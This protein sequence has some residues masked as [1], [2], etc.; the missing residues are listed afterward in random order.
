MFDALYI[1]ATG[2]QAQQ[3]N[4]DTIANNLANVN[5]DGFKKG[6]AAFSDLMVREASRLLPGSE[7]AE[8]LGMDRTLGAG[9][10]IANVSKLFDQ[11]GLKK[12]E[13]AYD[14][15][16][17]GEG[18]LEVTLPD[19]SSAYMRGGTFKVNRDGLL[20]T[21]GGFPL[22]PNLAIPDNAQSLIIDA[23]GKVS[24]R[25]AGE[26]KATELAR[27]DLVRFT[28][29]SGLQALG[30]GL[31]RASPES[32]EAIDA[33]AAEDGVGW[34]AQGYLEGSNVRL[35]EE[36]VTLMVAQRVY[37]ANVKVMQACD[38]MLGMING[39]RR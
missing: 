22:K 7:G 25:V 33:R 13:S 1:S 5:T 35:N 2:M 4:V 36:M 27:I 17:E 39:L 34:I 8:P 24:V 9:V 19:G 29:P 16:I 23:D 10:G 28:N 15:A 20:A 18:F 11:G 26:S 32:G 6:R 37:E 38:D 30:D 21:G 12:T 31:Y 3:L 14:L